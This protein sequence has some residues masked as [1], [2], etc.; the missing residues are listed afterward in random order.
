MARLP[1]EGVRIIDMTV[2]WAGPYATMMLADLGA[3][4]IRIESSQKF[5]S[6]TRGLVPYATKEMA[7]TMG[8]VGGSFPD[9][10]PGEHAFNRS[11]VFNAHARGKKSATAE[12]DTPEG[13]ELF[14]RLV[15]VSDI[16]IENNSVRVGDK[17]GFDYENLKDINPRIIVLRMPPL[18]K[19][20]PY[21]DFLGF[22]AN[23]EAVAGVTYPRAY[24]NAD[25]GVTTGTF[26]M[27][28]S[29]GA[30][31]AF[32]AMTALLQRERT[33]KGMTIEFPQIENMLQ[34]VGELFL[35]YSMNG[36]SAEPIGNLHPFYVQGCYPCAGHDQWIAMTIENDAQWEAIVEMMGHPEWVRRPEFA[37]AYGRRE[38]QEALDPLLAEWTR[39]QE[40]Y[41]LFHRLQ[42]AG[43]AAAPVLNEADVA[44]DP[45]VQAWNFFR[46]LSHP[47]IGTHLYPGHLWDYSV[48]EMPWGAPPP[49][50]GEH[51]EYVYKTLCG[52]SDEEYQRMVEKG[53]VA[54]E[55]ARS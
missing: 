55:Y 38:H 27:D 54:T 33:G 14:N 16:L 28:D 4:I 7:A 15:K 40:R 35:D 42:H 48:T 8:P 47:E 12:L 20:G 22:G 46:P 53:L 18:G 29:T 39:T 19:E 13:R 32:A 21:R 45:Q 9:K 43:I 49:A 5:P 34:Q 30:G 37:T 3:E 1:L 31:G 26:H 17:L 11:P 44:N 50:L 25:M 36:R 41:D 52:F 2:V 23:F 24:P 10:D 51:N 6:S